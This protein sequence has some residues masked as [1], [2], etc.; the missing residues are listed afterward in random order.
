MKGHARNL[1]TDRVQSVT[2]DM[3]LSEVAR[4]LVAARH[5]G[6][7]VVDAEQRVMGFVNELHVLDALL[8]GDV[9]EKTA[10]ELMSDP[11]IVADE[12]MS[13]DEVM[14]LFRDGGIHHLPVVRGGKLVGII[15][16]H[17]VLEHFVT[18]VLPEPPKNA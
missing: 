10:R 6:A 2:P 3:P 4:V 1:M 14:G 5:G 16:P 7:P 8:H 17:D 9:E 13:T 18:H 12:F 15:T 11:A